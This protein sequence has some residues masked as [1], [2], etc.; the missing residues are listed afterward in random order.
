[1]ARI[2]VV[3]DEELVRFALRKILDT[4]GHDV[5]EASD[6]LAGSLMFDDSTIDIVLVDII[7][8]QKN[9]IELITEIRK[10]R[11]DMKIIAISGGGKVKPTVFLELK[12]KHGV[13]HVLPKPFT[14]R[15][16]L[17]AVNDCLA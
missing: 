7:M 16:L 2:L 9:G 14:E 15:Q 5:I 1:M 11:P 3:D 13:E 17:E 12:Q 10:K 4:A 6:G 8:P